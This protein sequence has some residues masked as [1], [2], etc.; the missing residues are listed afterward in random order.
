[1]SEV[2]LYVPTSPPPTPAPW[3]GDT[4]TPPPPRLKLS[5]DP[6]SPLLRTTTTSTTTAEDGET[7]QS[8]PNSL[9]INKTQQ[10]ISQSTA[11]SPLSP[12]NGTAPQFP[13]QPCLLA[14]KY[15]VTKFLDSSTAEA[16]DLATHANLLVKVSNEMSFQFKN[17]TAD[18]YLYMPFI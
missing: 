10:N 6:L 9:S 7:Q 15:L 12:T 1:M 5:P 18:G 13:T 16:V 14:G 8:P 3:S 17:Y 4:H 11:G 2:L